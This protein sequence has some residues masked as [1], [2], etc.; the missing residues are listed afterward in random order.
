MLLFAN[1]HIEVAV[2]KMYTQEANPSWSDVTV[3][4]LL[5]AN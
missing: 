1:Y 5:G 2:W 3:V 4:L